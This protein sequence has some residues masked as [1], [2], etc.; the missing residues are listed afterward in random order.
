MSADLVLTNGNI[1]TMSSSNP[2]AQ[3]I[4]VKDNVIIKVGKNREVAPLIDNNTK[5]IQLKRK[6]VIP[7]FI[8]THIHVADFGRLLM[9]IDLNNCKS[10][11]DMQNILKKKIPNISPNKWIIG[12]GWK[13][14]FFESNQLPNRYDL[15]VAAPDNPVAFYH[16]SGKLCLVNSKALEFAKIT[17]LTSIPSV[18]GMIEKNPITGNPTGILK[19]KAMNLV[20]ATIPEPTEQDLL[21]NANLAC[22]KILENGITSVH[23]MV[24]SAKEFSIIKKLKHN[25]LLPRIFIV[26]PYELWKK[27]LGQNQKLSFLQ[28]NLLRIGAIEISV[29]GYLADKTAALIYPYKDGLNS[30]GKLLYSQKSLISFATEILQSNFQLIIHAMGDKAVDHA[31]TT[32]KQVKNKPQGTRIRLEQAALINKNLLDR[33]KNQKIMVSVQPCVMNSEFKIWSAVDNLGPSRA[34]WLYPI[35][36]LLD[37]NILLLG[38]SDCPM[39]PLNP[40]L[41]I[42]T[43][44]NKQ[45]FVDEAITV[46]QALAMYTINAAYS[47]GEEKSKGS[48]E[49]GKLADLVILSEDPI[50]ISSDK[51]GSINVDTTILGGK[52]VYS[53]ESKLS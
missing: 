29:D 5:L 31:L 53:K 51:I 46:T 33:L 3:A 42:Q 4:A 36:T 44:V 1:I 15:D 12:R 45:F 25:S 19:G 41:G 7:G 48:I 47:T 40:L 20:W 50:G 16:N 28:N 35:K 52:I 23:W 14:I 6:T 39:E 43:L 34:R 21:E 13:D 2:R 8:D 30:T 27:E 26:V 9:W 22:S 32:I 17:K 37:N 49:E 38:G 24:L 11:K 18:E 10:I